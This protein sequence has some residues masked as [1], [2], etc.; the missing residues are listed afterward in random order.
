MSTWKK[1]RDR[2]CPAPF[3]PKRREVALPVQ[4]HY[5]VFSLIYAAPNPFARGLGLL[6]QLDKKHLDC[7]I[8]KYEAWL[9]FNSNTKIQVQTF[10]LVAIHSYYAHRRCYLQQVVQPLPYLIMTPNNCNDWVLECE[11][12][13]SYLLMC[14][15]FPPHNVGIMCGQS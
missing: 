1:H 2:L 7:V 14:T 6:Q 9:C 8:L 15:S 5:T 10:D 13:T 12:L 3:M 4:S 11:E